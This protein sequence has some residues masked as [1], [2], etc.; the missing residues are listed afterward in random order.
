MELYSQDGTKIFAHPSQI[1]NMKR[2]GWSE[3]PPK[4]EANPEPIPAEPTQEEVNSDG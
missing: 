2:R 3:G 4:K 1:E